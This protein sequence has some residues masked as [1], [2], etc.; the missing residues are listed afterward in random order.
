MDDLRSPAIA[1]SSLCNPLGWYNNNTINNIISRKYVS[2]MQDKKTWWTLLFSHLDFLSVFCVSLS[3][4]SLW[5]DRIHSDKVKETG[6]CSPSLY[7]YTPLLRRRSR[8]GKKYYCSPT[9]DVHQHDQRPGK[10]YQ[11]FHW[12]RSTPWTELTWSSTSKELCTSEQRISG[13]KYCRGGKNRRQLDKN[14]TKTAPRSS[15]YTV[16]YVFNL[17]CNKNS[18]FL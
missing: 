6:F 12:E 8:S 16:L 14:R 1:H 13:W 10:E 9:V 7:H 11:V 15:N 5:R 18:E 4:I 17:F 3:W 2:I